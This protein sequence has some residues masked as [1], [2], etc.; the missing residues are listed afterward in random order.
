[1]KWKKV[2]TREGVDLPTV[3]DVDVIFYDICGK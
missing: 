1:M 2:A 3:S